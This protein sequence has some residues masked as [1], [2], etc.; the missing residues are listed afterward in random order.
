MLIFSLWSAGLSKFSYCI[1]HLLNV[2]VLA[3]PE[4]GDGVRVPD[5]LTQMTQQQAAK[6]VH[7]I[8]IALVNWYGEPPKNILVPLEDID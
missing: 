4:L 8:K 6:V 1:R 7:W 2:S 3:L 5:Q